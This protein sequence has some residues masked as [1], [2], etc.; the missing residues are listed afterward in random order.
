MEVG[1]QNPGTSLLKKGDI[2]PQLH[3]GERKG[4]LYIYIH[5]YLYIK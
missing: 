4:K 3:V 1:K 5:M 2:L